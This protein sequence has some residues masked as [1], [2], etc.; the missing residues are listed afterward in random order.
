[1]R[2]QSH[3]SSIRFETASGSS[4]TVS[5]P[6]SP[7]D[8]IKRFVLFHGKQHPATLGPIEVEAFLTHLAVDRNVAAATR[9]QARSAL[10][11][12]YKDVLGIELPWLDD[13][14]HAMGPTRL[15]VVLTRDEVAQVVREL[16]G[17]H[18][19]IGRLLYGSGM[20]ILECMRLR[21]KDVEFVRHEILVR[22]G[23]GAKD[24]ITMLP[25]RVTTPLREQVHNAWKVHQRDLSD[26]FGAAYLPA[27]LYRK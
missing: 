27:A 6:S 24:R 16:D 10:L 23:K 20:R 1:M 17:I 4:T 11:F 22:D 15:P 21:V 18:S 5:A 9:N 26:G 19:L 14:E 3:G 13:V 7:T 2:Y 8:W 25:L 12:L